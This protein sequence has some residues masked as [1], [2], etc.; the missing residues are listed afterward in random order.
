MGKWI[1][2]LDYNHEE[3]WRDIALVVIFK[4]KV[5]LWKQAGQRRLSIF[6]PWMQDYIP[7]NLPKKGNMRSVSKRPGVAKVHIMPTTE[8]ETTIDTAWLPEKVS[9][10]CSS[11]HKCWGAIQWDSEKASLLNAYDFLRG[12]KESIIRCR[13]VTNR[14]QENS[15]WCSTHHLV[16]LVGTPPEIL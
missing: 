15:D 5:F 1:G 11:C 6:R 4:C 2:S 10:G 12:K 3:P 13:P 14:C 16:S 7:R 9:G 8:K